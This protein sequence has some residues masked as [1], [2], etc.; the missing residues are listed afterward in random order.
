MEA[1]DEKSDESSST[2]KGSG[3]IKGTLGITP[4]IESNLDTQK[5]FTTQ[6]GVKKTTSFTRTISHI[7]ANWDSTKPRWVFYNQVWDT[8]LEGRIDKRKFATITVNSSPLIFR[9]R[10]DVKPKDIYYTEIQPIDSTTSINKKIILRTIITK[11]ILGIQS[12]L[13]NGDITE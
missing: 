8:C 7:K 5:E 2:E 3:Y 10:F 1:I 13:S 12:T 6:A 4:S 9:Y 11:M